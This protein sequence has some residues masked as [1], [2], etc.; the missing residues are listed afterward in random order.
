MKKNL[1]L[2]KYSNLNY[3]ILILVVS[4]W[5]SWWFFY[6]QGIAIIDRESAMS[7]V[8]GFY[9]LTVF[10][11]FATLATLL[12]SVSEVPNEAYVMNTLGII[13]WVNVI[14][15]TYSLFSSTYV[16]AL[17]PLYSW[18]LFFSAVLGFI[19]NVV[20]FLTINNDIRSYVFG[21]DVSA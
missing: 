5:I 2:F 13:C 12:A 4:S 1:K 17:T 9:K 20:I 8:A 7:N 21:E 14:D 10:L 11:V 18:L 6:D 19:F 3:V 16:T 15:G